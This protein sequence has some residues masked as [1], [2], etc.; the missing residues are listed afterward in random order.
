LKC[1]HGSAK[2]P[3]VFNVSSLT[4]QWGPVAQSV[5]RL[6]AGWTV[7]GSNPGGGEIFRTCPDRPWGQPSLLYDGYQVFPGVKRPGRGADQP[8]LLVPRLRMSR[9]I[10]ALPTRL[11]L[12]VHFTSH[13]YTSLRFTT[14]FDTS[15][16]SLQLTTLHFGFTPLKFRISPFYLTTLFDTSLPLFKLQPT[17]LNFGFTPFKFLTSPYHLTSL[18]FTPLHYTF[19]TSFPLILNSPNYTFMAY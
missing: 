9:A 5:E 3:A 6:T 2:S 16:P 11:F 18:H 4:F 8:P 19:D 14:L 12:P 15:L 7:R 13:H 17:T 10:S 1:N